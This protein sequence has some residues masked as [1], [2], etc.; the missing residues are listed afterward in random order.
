M[1]IVKLYEDELYIVYSYS[2]DSD[3]LDG[4]IK[5]EKAIGFSEEN[6]LKPM[7]DFAEIKSS[8][9]DKNNFFAMRALGFIVNIC[10]DDTLDFPEIKRF[11]WG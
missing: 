4:T 9:T 5:V 8:V 6:R 1:L 10:F 7:V 2:H 3:I 11:A